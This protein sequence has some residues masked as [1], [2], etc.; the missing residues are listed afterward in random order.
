MDE[1]SKTRPH[2]E[3]IEGFSAESQRRIE[4]N[5][6]LLNS[7]WHGPVPDAGNPHARFN[8]ARSFYGHAYDVF[9]EEFFNQGVPLDDHIL[10]EYIPQLASDAAIEHQWIWSL[11]GYWDTTSA[12]PRPF[13]PLDAPRPSSAWIPYGNYWLIPRVAD[14]TRKAL[15]GPRSK[16]KARQIMR[17]LQSP[18]FEQTSE[19][20]IGSSIAGWPE[21]FD[22]FQKLVFL[23]T[24]AR[25]NRED[26]D[27]VAGYKETTT[28]KNLGKR[29]QTAVAATSYADVLKLSPDEFVR[30][31]NGILKRSSGNS[32]RFT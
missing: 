29:K 2:R 22:A 23:K 20:R 19:P 16:W 15:V 7:R 12:P 13:L 4:A 21:R 5:L 24:G 17:S 3:I 28:R 1:V 6:L 25:I 32:P 14:Q 11:I 9:A 18:A 8:L 31:N 30:R 10:N 27:R 26:I